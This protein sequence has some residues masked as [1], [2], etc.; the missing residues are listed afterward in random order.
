VVVDSSRLD[1]CHPAVDFFERIGL[2]F[3]VGVNAFD[4]QL[5]HPLEDVRWALAVGE[6]TPVIS[7]DARDRL[8]VRDAL[9]VVLD[10]ALAKATRAKAGSV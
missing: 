2:P 5:R 1:D 7:F 4:G 8:S 9:L 10:Q 6:Q 3:A